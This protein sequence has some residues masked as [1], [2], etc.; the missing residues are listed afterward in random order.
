MS[1]DPPPWATEFI[2]S[3]H[4][5]YMRV[6]RN[7]FDDGVLNVGCFKNAPD[8]IADGMS[9]EWCKYSSAENCRNNATSLP[10]D[11]AVISLEVGAI[12]RIA[13]ESKDLA[14]SVEHTPIWG[15]PPLRDVRAHSDV[16]GPKNAQVRVLL[17]RIWRMEIGI[18]E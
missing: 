15:T 5:L 6:H 17:N 16:F 14:Q 2:P 13:N 1:D 12:R 7:W 8:K 9:T 18:E 10:R 3:E 11:N 4:I